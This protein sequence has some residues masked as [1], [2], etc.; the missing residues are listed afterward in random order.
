MV[1]G[2]VYLIYSAYFLASDTDGMDSFVNFMLACTYFLLGAINISS[3]IKVINMVSQFITFR[4]N[5]IP[6]QF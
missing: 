4:D 5:Q 3:L 1:M 2:L 6:M